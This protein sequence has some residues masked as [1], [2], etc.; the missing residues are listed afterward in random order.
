MKSLNP[1]HNPNNYAEPR[2]RELSGFSVLSP[3]PKFFAELFVWKAA[4]PLISLLTTV[5]NCY[6]LLYSEVA[7]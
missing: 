5:I 7:V 2:K 6:I 4:F 1:K 3:L